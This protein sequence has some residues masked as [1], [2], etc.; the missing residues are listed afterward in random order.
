MKNVFGTKTK[1]STEAKQLATHIA[2]KGNTITKNELKNLPN[3]K[4]ID[5]L[6]FNGYIDFNNYGEAILFYNPQKQFKNAWFK[7][8]KTI[9]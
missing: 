9:I 7:N 8:R 3:G 2:N 1:L 6:G 4:F 5:E